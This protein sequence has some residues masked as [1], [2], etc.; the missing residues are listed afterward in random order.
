MRL[1]MTSAAGVSL[2]LAVSVTGHS[3]E[4][5]QKHYLKVDPV[6]QRDTVSILAALYGETRTTDAA[7]AVPTVRINLSISEATSLK[8]WISARKFDGVS[9]ANSGANRGEAPHRHQYQGIKKV[10]ERQGFEPWIP[11]RAYSL[12]R[13]APSTTR[14]SLRTGRFCVW[15]LGGVIRWGLFLEMECGIDGGGGGCTRG[16]ASWPAG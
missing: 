11:F 6:R 12:S 13:R 3:R 16:L 14:P 4:I 7:E 9:G 8:Q 1:P 2:D 5:A 10:A 15:F